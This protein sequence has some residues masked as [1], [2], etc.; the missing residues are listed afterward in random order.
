MP[1][2]LFRGLFDLELTRVIPFGR[3]FTL[4]WL[5]AANRTN[6]GSQDPFDSS[7]FHSVVFPR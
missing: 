1:E 2:S 6:P 3:L 4:R 7:I 5:F